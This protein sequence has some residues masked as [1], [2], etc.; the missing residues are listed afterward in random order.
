[1]AIWSSFFYISFYPGTIRSLRACVFDAANLQ[2]ALRQAAFEFD[3]N[4][5]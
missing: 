3:S 4:L 1:M 2:N 5:L